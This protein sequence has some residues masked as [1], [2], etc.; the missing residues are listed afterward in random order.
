MVSKVYTWHWA[1]KMVR[2]HAHGTHAAKMIGHVGGDVKLLGRHTAAHTWYHL[3]RLKSDQPSGS[4]SLPSLPV[5]PITSAGG[6][7]GHLPAMP[8]FTMGALWPWLAWWQLWRWQASRGEIWDPGKEGTG[9]EC[10][11]AYPLGKGEKR[12]NHWENGAET[13]Q[14]GAN[15]V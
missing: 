2:I 13:E 6:G 14:A 3:K 5:L 9:V 11:R 8:T 4:T 7:D 15:T 10:G 1:N 12:R